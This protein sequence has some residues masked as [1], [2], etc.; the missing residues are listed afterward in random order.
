VNPL[1][2]R[3]LS[4]IV[5]L[6]ASSPFVLQGDWPTPL[7]PS[8]LELFESRIRPV[9]IE[10]C[11]ACHNSSE[12]AEGG[13]VLD[14]RQGLMDGGDRGAAIVPGRPQTSK[15][16]A[17]LKHEIDGLEMP[18]GGP[19]LDRQIIADFENRDSGFLSSRPLRDRFTRSSEPKS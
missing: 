4:L 14:H 12:P 5:W 9:L 7:S 17:V 15:L 2:P 10:H 6:L 16:I 8:Q 11:Y 18:D 3:C 13:F 19:K 1:P